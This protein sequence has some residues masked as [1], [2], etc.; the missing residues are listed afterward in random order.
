VCW[1]EGLSDADLWTICAQ[2]FDAYAPDP[3]VGCAEGLAS[4]FYEQQLSCEVNGTPYA[5]HANIVG[6][7][8]GGLANKEE[9]KG[10]WLR[11]AQDLATRFKFVRRP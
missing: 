6:W 9:M 1:S 10:V 5:E 2:H 3:A 8:S 4:S 11:Q 7:K